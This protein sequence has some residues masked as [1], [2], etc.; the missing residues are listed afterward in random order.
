MSIKLIALIGKSASGKDSILN[1]VLESGT[2]NNIIHCT[3]RPKRKNEEE[4]KDYYFMSER[5]FRKEEEKGNFLTVNSFNNWFYGIR[6]DAFVEDKINIGVFSIRELKM[7][8]EK[9]PNLNIF[10]VEIAADSNV[11]LLR[12]LYRVGAFNE[13]IVAEICRRYFADE[14]DFKEENLEFLGRRKII[15]NN[16]TSDVEYAAGFLEGFAANWT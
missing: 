14:I 10:I 1:K 6:R 13:E 9:M 2:M 5:D 16:F 8:K 4:G 3:T 11:R 12:S 7:L 15:K